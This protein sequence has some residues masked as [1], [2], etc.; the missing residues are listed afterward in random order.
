MHLYT[1]QYTQM[2]NETNLEGAIG[3]TTKDILMPPCPVRH[4]RTVAFARLYWPD[5]LTAAVAPPH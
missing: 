2:Q 4:E 3:T 1:S 5:I